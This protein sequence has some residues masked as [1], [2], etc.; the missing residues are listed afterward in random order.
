MKPDAD[1][2]IYKLKLQIVSN[3]KLEQSKTD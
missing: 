3:V 2:L 1:I